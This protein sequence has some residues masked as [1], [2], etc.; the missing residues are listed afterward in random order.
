MAGNDER[1]QDAAARAHE[2]F[3]ERM[4]ELR[5]RQSQLLR[6]VIE[7]IDAEMAERLRAEMKDKEA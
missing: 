3:L 4:R 2:R 5:A 1:H 7:R 6:R